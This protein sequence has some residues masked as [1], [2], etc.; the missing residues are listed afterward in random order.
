MTIDVTKP[1]QLDDG[2][3]VEYVR[4]NDSGKIRVRILG[5]KHPERNGRDDFWIDE[6]WNYHPETGVWVGGNPRDYYVLQNVPEVTPAVDFSK[7][8]QTRSGQPVTILATGVQEDLGTRNARLDGQT[9]AYRVGGSSDIFYAHDNGAYMDRDEDDSYD[10]INFPETPERTSEFRSFNSRGE[11]GAGPRPALFFGGIIDRTLE[12]SKSQPEF[13]NSE[14][15][16]ELI[17]EGERLV[18]VK[19]HPKDATTS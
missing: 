8:C 11:G 6:A 18:D 10:I 16:L 1:L 19:F 5:N 9:V 12:A 2:T 7:P 14:G 13:L 17:R 15:F 4:M 3:P